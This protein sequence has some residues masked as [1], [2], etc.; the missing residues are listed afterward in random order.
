SDQSCWI[1][2]FTFKT[3]TRDRRVRCGKLLLLFQRG[4]IR[5]NEERHVVDDVDS[6]HQITLAR[7]RL[8]SRQVAVSV[9]AG[10][11][12]E[13]A[14]DIP[15]ELRRNVKASRRVGKHEVR[16]TTLPFTITIS[17]RWRQVSRIAFG[18]ARIDPLGD[19]GNL[20]VGEPARAFK[21]IGIRA[22]GVKAD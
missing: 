1:G 9:E 11:D 13:T 6:S 4:A 5:I 21:G 18:S 3:G 12:R 19:G 10:P 22:T 8:E 2:E 7:Q 14:K 20:L 17:H 16:L 15:V